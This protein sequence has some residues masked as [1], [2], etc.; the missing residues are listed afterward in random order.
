MKQFCSSTVKEF[1]QIVYWNP[2]Q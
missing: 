1:S 2:Q